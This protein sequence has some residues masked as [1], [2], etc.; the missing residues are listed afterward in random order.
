[1]KPAANPDRFKP[2]PNP[3][4]DAITR[5]VLAFL[6]AHGY[7]AWRQ[8]NEGRWDPAAQ[9]WYPHPNARRGVPDIIGFRR[10]DGL[11]IGVEVKAGT[12]QLHREQLAFLDELRAAGG[13][14]FVARSFQKF[15]EQFER[16]GLLLDPAA[17][18]GGSIPAPGVTVGAAPTETDQPQ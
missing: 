6:H 1:M 9:R 7:C 4:A 18:P 3:T 8:I 12:D 2:Q 15:Q 13:L 10:R 5:D 11:F 17:G 14:A 16:R